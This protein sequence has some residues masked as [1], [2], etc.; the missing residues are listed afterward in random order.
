MDKKSG[1]P[2]EPGLTGTALR[3]TIIKPAPRPRRPA[4]GAPAR[5][6]AGSGKLAPTAIPGVQRKRL[7]VSA[8]DLKRL[9]PLASAEVV[10]KALVQLE[11]F[12][13]QN[14]TERTAILWGHGLQEEYGRTV[15]RMLDLSRRPE[16]E[17]AAG[18]VRRMTEIL[19]SIDL[20]AVRSGGGGLGQYFKRLNDRVDTVAELDAARTEL[21]QLIALMAASLDPLLTLKGKIEQEA[22]ATE[23]LANDI[24]SAALAADYLS[25]LPALQTSGLT[26]IFLD[27]SLGLTRTLAQIRETSTLRS[28]QAGQPLSIISAIQNV[29]LVTVP[30]WLSSLAA[31][32]AVLG[33]QRAP[34]PT[35]TGEIDHRRRVILQELKS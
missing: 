25:N 26:R 21:D 9:A 1:N 12:V 20:E 30:G 35:E 31:I 3:P 7:D 29:A 28:A 4:G 23:G 32:T 17:K 2:P 24:K 6:V 15:S 10:R 18:Y 33:G 5:Q 22:L 13:L 8:A 19:S 27:R 14:A 34:T 11:Q 16:L